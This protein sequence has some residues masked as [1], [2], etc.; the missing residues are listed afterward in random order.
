MFTDMPQPSNT[1]GNCGRISQAD[2]CQTCSQRRRCCG[3][4]RY[5][6]DN[7][8]EAENVNICQVIRHLVYFLYHVIQSMKSDQCLNSEENDQKS[9]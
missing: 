2:L 5:F 9:S 1:C 3:C 6:P 4:H 8:F 7:C